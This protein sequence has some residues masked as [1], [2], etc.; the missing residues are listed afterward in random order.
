MNLSRR[1]EAHQPSQAEAR[2]RQTAME[3]ERHWHKTKALELV[4]RWRD[5][6][7]QFS[8]SDTVGAQTAA[9]W[10]YRCAGDLES[11]IAER[12]R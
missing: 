5:V 10:L 3:A 7:G 12:G 1:E 4:E 2:S 6:A 8:Q 11:L 9:G